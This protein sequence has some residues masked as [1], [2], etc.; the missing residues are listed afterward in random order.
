MDIQHL[1]L[2][3]NSVDEDFLWLNVQISGA[4]TSKF[5]PREDNRGFLLEKG[6]DISKDTNTCTSNLV[7][8]LIGFSRRKTT[9]Q[10]GV[11]VCLDSL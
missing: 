8:D 3:S 2:H 5:H 6:C 10:F 4:K 1:L 7:I 9:E 11:F